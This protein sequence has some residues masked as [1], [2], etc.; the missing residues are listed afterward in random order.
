VWLRFESLLVIVNTGSKLN[1]NWDYPSFYGEDSGVY[2]TNGWYQENPNLYNPYV[3]WNPNPYPFEPPSSYTYLIPLPD[4]ARSYR[5]SISNT[6]PA[7]YPWSISPTC[8]Q[9]TENHALSSVEQRIEALTKS[10]NLT[11]S[12]HL[13]LEE[14]LDALENVRRQ[15][16]IESLR[17]Q[18][19]T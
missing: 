12:P 15:Q 13:S 8:V 6:Q 5:D 1:I 16:S 17:S 10:C 7:C 14:K 18:L 11:L 4:E 2:Q 19:E 3:S 9:S